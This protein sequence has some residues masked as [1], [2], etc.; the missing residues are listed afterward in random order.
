MTWKGGPGGSKKTIFSLFSHTGSA[1]TGWWPRACKKAS[2]NISIGQQRISQTRYLATNYPHWLDHWLPIFL[3][4]KKLWKKF[5]SHAQ[6]EK[7]HKNLSRISPI[8]MAWPLF[9]RLLKKGD[10]KSREDDSYS[11]RK[12]HLPR[13]SHELQARRRRSNRRVVHDPSTCK[14]NN[15]PLFLLLLSNAFTIVC[16][17]RERRR[18]N[19]RLKERERE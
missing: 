14:W 7:K 10:G 9:Y 2:K 1:H 8:P 4:F 15:V 6:P 16:R 11:R 12:T 5:C 19:T 17:E 18:K 13:R 3:A